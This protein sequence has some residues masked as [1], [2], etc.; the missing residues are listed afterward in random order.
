MIELFRQKDDWE[1]YNKG[2]FSHSIILIHI[3]RHAGCIFRH[4]QLDYS[5]QRKV[6]DMN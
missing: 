3:K 1:I 2:K 4:L 6:A 5:F